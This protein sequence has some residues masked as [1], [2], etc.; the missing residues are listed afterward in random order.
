MTLN[1]LDIRSHRF[2]DDLEDEHLALLRRIAY[3]LLALF[4]S[5]TLRSERSRRTP[6]KKLMRWVLLATLTATQSDVFR[7]RPRPA[8]VPG[9]S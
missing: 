6:W 1:G 2:F 9:T 8:A 3:N 4:R 5:V 7:L